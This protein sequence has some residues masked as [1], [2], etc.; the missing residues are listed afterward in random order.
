MDWH[1]IGDILGLLMAFGVGLGVGSYSTMPYYRLP[2]KEPCA[3]KWIGKKSH[4]T[5][6]NAQLRTRDLVPVF[7]WIG[8]RGKCFSCKTPINPVYFFIELSVTIISV[9]AWL[10]FGIQDS[11]FYL[12]T[13]GLGAC[14]VIAAATDYSFKV[15]PDPLFVVMVL[16]AF[17]YQ[18]NSFDAFFDMVYVFTCAVMLALASSKL[19]PKFSGRELA[20]FRYLKLLAVAGLWLPLAKFGLFLLLCPL[21][22]IPVYLLGAV[23]KWKKPYPLAIAMGIALLIA[24]LG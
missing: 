24:H 17:L 6:C 21:L 3:G 15:I 11:H 19:Y 18:G 16:L 5:V 7:N 20:N 12:F 4:C 23:L 14:L 13:L 10:R 8:T 1:L 2:N 22:A 9:L